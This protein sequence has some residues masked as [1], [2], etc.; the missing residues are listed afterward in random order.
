[1]SPTSPSVNVDSIDSSDRLKR[2]ASSSSI[3]S[4]GRPMIAHHGSLGALPS[5]AYGS[6]YIKIWAGLCSLETDPHPQVA[7]I[8]S[9][10]TNFVRNQVKVFTMLSSLILLP[11]HVLCLSFIQPVKLLCFINIQIYAVLFLHPRPTT[12][13]SYGI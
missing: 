8:C 2:V 3:S 9:V 1:M 7:Q 4:L 6:V 10:I 12:L 5:V 13:Q 11:V